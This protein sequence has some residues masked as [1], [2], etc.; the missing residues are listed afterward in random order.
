[1]PLVVQKYGGSSVADAELIRSVARRICNAKG[2]G[3]D[4]VVV[5][6]AMGNTMMSFLN[7]PV[8]SSQSLTPGSWT[9]SCLPA[10]WY[11]V[12]F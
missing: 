8:R 9:S 3:N 7:W 1:M 6:S 2:Q 12:H 4:V 11:P 10:N 5:V